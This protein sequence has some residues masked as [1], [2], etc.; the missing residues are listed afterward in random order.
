[1][2]PV[3][4]NFSMYEFY[5]TNFVNNIV[6][7][8]TDFNIPFDMIEIEVTETTT[9]RN[10]FMAIAIVNQLRS[11]G[12]RVLM[13]DFGIGYSNLDNLM[14]IPFDTVKID[15]SYVQRM[16][17]DSKSRELVKFL[18]NLC[19]TNNLEVI[20]EGVDNAEQVDMLRKLHCD[21]IQG[22]YYSKPLPKKEYDA[23]IMSNSFEKKKKE[24]K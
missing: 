4:I 1:M 11:Y 10:T 17:T 24:A 7:T 12:I 16:L 20:A 15:K 14:R 8:I 2:I 3:S 5:D 18:I 13:D 19:K 23:F 9:Q 22:Y 6:N 21:E